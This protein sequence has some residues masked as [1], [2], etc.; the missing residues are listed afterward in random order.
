MSETVCL[1]SAV[2]TP[3]G[4]FGGCLRSLKPIDLMQLVIKEAMARARAAP[5]NID[6]VIVGNCFAPL[7]QNIARISSLLL[8]LPYET[9]GHIINC[10]CSSGMQAIITGAMAIALGNAGVVVAGGVESMSNAPYILDSARWGQRLRHLQG[11]DLIWASMQEYPVGGGMGVAAERLADKYG[12][13]RHDLDELAVSSHRRAARAI[14]EE[15]FQREIVPV[16]VSAGKGKTVVVDTDEHPRGDT[17]ME[18]LAPLKAAFKEGGVVTAGN[19]SSLNDGAAAVVIASERRAKE[20][21]LPILARLRAHSFVAVDPHLVGIA[22]IPAIKRLLDLSGYSLG[23]IQLFEINEAFASY[24]LSC[25]REL[26]LD[27]EITNVNG[28]GISLGH[29]VGCT[30][31]RILVTLYYEM[32]RQGLE[33]GIASLCAGGG[34]GTGI[35]LER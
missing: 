12:L 3:I 20:L 2:R 25:E 10:A 6:Q 28:S 15:R 33:R 32:D 22:P 14:E 30:G 9:P 23:D 18:A 34:V 11:K 7:E 19:A 21:G 1:V 31:C 29:P 27:R 13:T 4:D 24:Y 16:Q 8:G 17:T 5:A 35:L 26:G